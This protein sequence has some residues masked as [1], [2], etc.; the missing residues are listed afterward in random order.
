M[1]QNG[2]K[3]IECWTHYKTLNFELTHDLDRIFRYSSSNLKNSCIMLPIFQPDGELFAYDN[4][5]QILKIAVFQ[6]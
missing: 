4:Q 5:F 3:S 2:W 1:E 6:E